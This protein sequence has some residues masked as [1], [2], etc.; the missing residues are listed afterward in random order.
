MTIEDNVIT[1]LLS[2]PI[3]FRR[4]MQLRVAG[5]PADG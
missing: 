5:V 3:F 1:L 2:E 4:L